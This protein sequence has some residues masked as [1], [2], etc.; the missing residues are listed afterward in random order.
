MENKY[1]KVK[2]GLKEAILT[3]KY[4]V[5]DK[6]PTET[7]LMAMYDVSHYTVRRAVGDL[8]GSHFIYRI[9]GGGMFV[10]DWHKDWSNDNDSKMI[11]VITT[12]I[13]DYIFPDII[14]GIDR[15]ISEAGYSLLISNTHNNHEKER[16]SLINMLDTKV[17]GLI[18]EPTQSALRNPNMDLYQEI[19]D[20][21]IPTLFINA[22]Y[23]DLDFPSVTTDD[24][25]A[26]ERMLEY[27]FRM[28]HQSVLGVFQVDDIQGVN[29][30]NGF[31]QAYQRHPEFSYQSNLIMYQSGD[32][33]ERVMG[34][35]RI[36]L[37]QDER[38][39]AI[40]CYNDR[41]AIQVM[42][43]LRSNDYRVPEDVS[44]VGFDDYLMSQY[45]SPSL[46]TLNHE[47]ERMGEDAGRMLIKL[48]NREDV[49]DINYE[50]DLVRRNSVVKPADATVD[51][52]TE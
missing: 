26:E 17:A 49:Q 13:A 14:S 48:L 11:G 33:F 12:H 23:P 9:Q 22:K 47:K 42:D 29:R 4:K 51:T 31:V 39:T 10:Q 25:A 2:D 43:Y 40:A 32:D 52:K 27:L 6:L 30:M 5:N 1:Q 41:L 50:P 45:M 3:G 24:K 19:K 28:G 35:I 15:I 21:Q 46:T 18:I 38:P 44:V 36:Y 34:R 20:D 37:E 8:E 16:K 7:E